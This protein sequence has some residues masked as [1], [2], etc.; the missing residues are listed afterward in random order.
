M[1]VLVTILICLMLCGVCWAQDFCPNCRSRRVSS[2]VDIDE[3]ITIWTIN[4]KGF[5]YLH[6][7]SEYLRH[8]NYE[9]SYAECNTCG[10]RIADV[11][12]TSV[13]FQEDK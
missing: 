7:L 10:A 6:T 12:P 13:I 1:R 2:G 11:T 5:K 3:N 9:V 4:V 8:C